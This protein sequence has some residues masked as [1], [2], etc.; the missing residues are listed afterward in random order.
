MITA[1]GALVRKDLVQSFRNPGF[2]IIGIVLPVFFTLLYSFIV[3]AATTNPLYVA[4]AAEGP[5]T[6]RLMRILTAQSSEDGKAW[7]LVTADPQVAER[8]FENGEAMGIVRIPST[9]EEDVRA[10]DA[11]VGLGVYNINSDITKNLQLRLTGALMQFKGEVD[12]THQVQVQ[13][14]PRWEQEMGF[15]SYMG[16]SLVMF[17]LIYGGMVNTG[18]LIAREWEEGTAK[19]VVLS[20]K[21]FWP[22][23]LGKW[24]A[25]FL[26]SLVTMALVLLTLQFT[27]PYPVSALGPGTWGP[28]V[29]LFFY[30]VALGALLGVTLRRSL[31]LVP[32]AAVVALIH[33][34][35]VGLESYMR[36]YAHS[37]L[38]EWLWY[39]V[40][41]WPVGAVT[42][43]IRY[44]AEGIE[45][46]YGMQGYMW[47]M[48]L[49]V[50]LLTAAALAVLRRKLT[51]AQGQ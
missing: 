47:W 7:K 10:G 18:N 22:L 13:E 39:A 41:W 25:T 16:A 17:S 49:L 3:Q 6:E 29:V 26:Q 33:F 38:L 43:H 1:A 15:A 44:S 9:F 30:G 14:S 28:I 4:K 46:V 37:G 31:P 34:L 24:T 27:L 36:G 11:R 32:I 20:P 21:G 19:A 40:R 50:V 12:P 51:F 5:A 35:L 42:D 8:S 48:V 2:L 23:V 45:P